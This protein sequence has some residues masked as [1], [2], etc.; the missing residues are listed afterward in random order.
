MHQK[1]FRSVSSSEL[2]FRYMVCKFYKCTGC[3]TCW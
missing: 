1:Y 3:R 2:R